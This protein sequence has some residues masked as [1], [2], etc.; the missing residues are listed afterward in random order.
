MYS[1]LNPGSKDEGKNITQGCMVAGRLLLIVSSSLF[2]LQDNRIWFVSKHL[3]FK[4][5]FCL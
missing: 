4:W 1:I 3:N 5:I 2:W